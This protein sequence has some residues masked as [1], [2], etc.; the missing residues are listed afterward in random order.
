MSRNSVLVG[1]T[2][3]RFEVSQE[4]VRSRAEESSR[5]EFVISSAEK[6]M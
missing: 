2:D 3:K 4:W 6:E 5:S 1:F